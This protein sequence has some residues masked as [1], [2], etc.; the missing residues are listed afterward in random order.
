MGRCS[1]LAYGALLSEC[2]ELIPWNYSYMRPMDWVLTN[3]TPYSGMC[4]A[5]TEPSDVCVALWP[6]A[7]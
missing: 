7:S 2:S 4:F 5:V 3:F 6:S 1:P